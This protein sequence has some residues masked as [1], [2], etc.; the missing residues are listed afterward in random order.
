LRRFDYKVE[1]GAEFVA[2]WPVFDVGAFE[3]F[4]K[5]IELAGLPVAGNWIIDWPIG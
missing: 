5:R 3:A 1:A 2:T 4:L